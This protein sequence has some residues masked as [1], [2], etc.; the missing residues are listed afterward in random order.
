[1]SLMNT[2]TKIKNKIPTNGTQQYIKEINC[3]N[4]VE[5]ILEMQ[6]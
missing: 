3:G 1:M 2:D 5:F 6:G 4:Q